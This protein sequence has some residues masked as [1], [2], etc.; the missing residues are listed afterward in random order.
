MKA[1]SPGGR[2]GMPPKRRGAR[3]AARAAGGAAAA[4]PAPAPAPA[5]DA[6]VEGTEGAAVAEGGGA[7]T[8]TGKGKGEGKGTSP[9][10]STRKR[11]RAPAAKANGAGAAAEEEAKGA[12][13]GGSPAKSAA[14]QPAAKAKAQP[15]AAPAAKKPRKERKDKGK[16]RARKPVADK[17]KGKDK[18]PPLPAL[19][20]RPHLPFLD[21]PGPGGSVVKL[22][23]PRF[24]DAMVS[25]GEVGLPGYNDIGLPEWLLRGDN[26]GRI[27]AVHTALEVGPDLRVPGGG[28]PVW[29]AAQ[30]RRQALLEEAAKH[31]TGPAEPALAPA[32]APAPAAGPGPL[33][34]LGG[35]AGAGGGEGTPLT[36]EERQRGVKDG[37]LRAF[38]VEMVTG[39]CVKQRNVAWQRKRRAEELQR[40]AKNCRKEVLA[41]HARAVKSLGKGSQH[42]KRL[43][44]EMVLFWRR[45]EKDS[46]VDTKAKQREVT[47][48]RKKEEELREAKRAQQRLN[49]LLTQTELYSHFMTG[50]LGEGAPP[51]AAANREAPAAPITPLLPGEQLTEQEQEQEQELRSMAENA[52]ET[53]ARKTVARAK[54]FDKEARG[55]RAEAAAAGGGAGDGVNLMQPSTMLADQQ[56]LTQPRRLRGTLKRYQLDGLR[57][58]ASLYE[59]GLNGI[60]ADEMGLGKTVQAIS[61]IAHLHEDKG[62]AGPFLVIAPSSTLHNWDKEIRGFYP[63][64]KVL[65]YWGSQEDR[66]LSRQRLH[67]KKIYAEGADNV[68]VT[69]YDLILK[70]EKYLKKVKWAY[71]VLDEAQAIKN[72]DALRW[73][74]LLSFS[75]RNRLLLTGTPI[76]NNMAELWALLHFIMPEIFDSHEQF[77]EWFSKGIENH[78][79][80]IQGMSEHTLKRLHVILQPFMLR[81]VKSD[82]ESDM[83]PKREVEVACRLSQ[84]QQSLYDR[85]RHKISIADLFQGGAVNEKKFANLMNIVIQLRKV[86]N[87]PEIFEKQSEKSPLYF[88]RTMPCLT[89]AVFGQLDWLWVLAREPLIRFHL[90]RLLYAEGLPGLANAASGDQDG[91]R[92]KWARNRLSPFAPLHMH[93]ASLGGDRYK[94]FGEPLYSTGFRFLRFCGLDPGTAAK[95]AA[96]EPYHGWRLWGL[97]EGRV[98]RDR[99]SLWAAAGGSPG[100]SQFRML[101]VP[102]KA[103]WKGFRDPHGYLACAAAGEGGPEPLILKRG[104]RYVRATALLRRLNAYVPAVRAPAPACVCSDPNHARKSE[105]VAHSPWVHR[106]LYGFP[107][108]RP[109]QGVDGRD[110]ALGALESRRVDKKPLLAPLHRTLGASA[111]M[112]FYA[113]AKALVD[114]CKLQALDRLLPKLKAEGH[115]V[116]IFAQMIQMMNLIEE[117]LVSKRI[118]FLRL[119]GS[120]KLEDR[121]D[122]VN[123]FQETDEYF[124]FMLSTRAGGLGINLTA[125]DTVIF[126]ESDWNPTMD[127]QAMDRAHRLGQT[128]PVTVYRLICKGTVE[129][130]I[131]KRASQKNKVQQLVMTGGGKSDDYFEAEEMVDLLL[132]DEEMAARLKE[133]RDAEK[134]AGQPKATT[135]KSKKRKGGPRKV[136]AKMDSDEAVIAEMETYAFT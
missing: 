59:Q 28:N 133:K 111:P 33:A 101:L 55:L 43:S 13:N 17:G 1:G 14:K 134:K 26:L 118:K 16:P 27:G 105:A 89:L 20:A 123:Q 94:P 31:E 128:R 108:A 107:P 110:Y 29:A 67:P 8:P 40:L 37:I 84:K 113:M 57:W 96:S 38:W 132:D 12:A 63:E 32:P 4:A 52:A 10:G 86:C 62:I 135:S 125:A 85:I 58:L 49:F 15:G 97:A 24:F 22:R 95:L 88:S 100:A 60:L 35:A 64:F 45:A 104:E 69:S 19:S 71:M 78:A 56:T 119:D 122:M 44:K 9:P 51:G 115:R 6:P 5:P 124:V 39:A 126:Y 80:G 81:R 11:R 120:T 114:G 103:A 92:R 3:A 129:E 66:K 130:K 54:V 7:A 70:D 73:K 102:Q 131:L 48:A 77:N 65:P 79:Q 127:L 61:F 25:H 93:R 41:R 34:P 42:V 21:A 136:R 87:H 50:K 75:C 106:E 112:Q 72:A 91:Y 30:R 121:K 83:A 68:V 23:I 99:G 53:R 98:N 2:P 82:V 36:P 76:Q 90:P 117:Y 74:T 18:P 116:L 109:A 47:Q 46:A